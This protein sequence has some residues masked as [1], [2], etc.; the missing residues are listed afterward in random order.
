MTKYVGYVIYMMFI[1][2]ALAAKSPWLNHISWQDIYQ[3]S[4]KHVYTVLVTEINA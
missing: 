1:S 4:D 2:A 3:A